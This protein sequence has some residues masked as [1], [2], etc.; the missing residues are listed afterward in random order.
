MWSKFNKKYKLSSQDNKI[1]DIIYLNQLSNLKQLIEIKLKGNPITN[2]DNYRENLIQLIPSLKK[3]D[4]IVII[5]KERENSKINELKESLPDHNCNSNKK[6]QTINTQK[7]FKFNINNNDSEKIKISL[8]QIKIGK[9]PSSQSNK[10]I[11][12]GI[13]N[14]DNRLSQRLPLDIGQFKINDDKK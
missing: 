7:S 2:I 9:P 14:T 12:N 8:P 10:R 11:F 5:E 1:D 3:I 6:N 4:E 13:P